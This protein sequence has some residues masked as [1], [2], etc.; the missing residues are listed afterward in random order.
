MALI[1][2]KYNGKE[3]VSTDITVDITEDLSKFKQNSGEVK[4][5]IDVVG[6]YEGKRSI[7]EDVYIT[8]I[9][10]DTSYLSLKSNSTGEFYLTAFNSTEGVMEG[11]FEIVYKLESGDKLI[12]NCKFES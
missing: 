3:E 8:L 1:R 12:K 9:D 5:V 7:G 2:Y 11:N 4:I 10:N 6:D